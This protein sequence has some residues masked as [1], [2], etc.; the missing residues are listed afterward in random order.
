[1]VAEADTPGAGTLADILQGRIPVPATP[2]VTWAGCASGPEKTLGMEDRVRPR[3]VISPHLRFQTSALLIAGRP[4]RRRFSGLRR[5]SQS[6]ATAEFFLYT[7]IAAS[8]SAFPG[9]LHRD[10]S[11]MA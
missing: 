6:A 10:V 4:S 2:G 3:R 8:S 7:F 1:M 9:F 5:N 11:S